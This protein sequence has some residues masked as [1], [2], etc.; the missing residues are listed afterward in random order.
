M[1]D[2]SIIKFVKLGKKPPLQHLVTVVNALVELIM[3]IHHNQ[4][5]WSEVLANV[6][7]VVRLMEKKPLVL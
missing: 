7:L 5:M 4:K 1:E 2:F 3:E 6:F